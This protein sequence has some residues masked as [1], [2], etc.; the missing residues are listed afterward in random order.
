LLVLIFG[1]ND[2]RN[3]MEIVPDYRN[4]K[5]AHFTASA[6]ELW[7]HSESQFSRNEFQSMKLRTRFLNSSETTRLAPRNRAVSKNSHLGD[8]VTRKIPRY[9]YFMLFCMRYLSSKPSNSHSAL[10]APQVP[11]LLTIV[12]VY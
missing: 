3:E 5:P 10:L 9:Q 2:F 7:S 12:R 6:G 4:V 8:I 11:L 1:E